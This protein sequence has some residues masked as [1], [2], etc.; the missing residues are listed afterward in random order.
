MVTACTME[1]LCKFVPDILKNISSLGY[2]A[3]TLNN[4]AEVF[5]LFFFYI[6]PPSWVYLCMADLFYLF[7]CVSGTRI[8]FFCSVRSQHS[9]GCFCRKTLSPGTLHFDSNFLLAILCPFQLTLSCPQLLPLG[10]WWCPVMCFALN[11]T[12]IS[13]FFPGTWEILVPLM[14][15]R[16]LLLTSDMGLGYHKMNF[17]AWY[18]GGFWQCRNFVIE[19][20]IEQNTFLE[21]F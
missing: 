19:R 17:L 3:Q 11:D 13:T 15:I 18:L 21:C 16:F 4:H 5:S 9:L 20:N 2:S 12:F 14:G 8:Y 6:S 10:H 7:Y 1:G